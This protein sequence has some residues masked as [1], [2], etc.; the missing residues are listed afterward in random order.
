MTK[1]WFAVQA[2]TGDGCPRIRLAES[3]LVLGNGVRLAVG[4]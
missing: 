2:E 3:E 1:L 4:G